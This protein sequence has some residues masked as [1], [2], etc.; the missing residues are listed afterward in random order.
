MENLIPC[1]ACGRLVSRTAENCP[2]C[3]KG[4]KKSQSAVGVVA[5]LVIGL[6][7]G[8]LLLHLLGFL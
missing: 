1:P 6:F 3:G 2:N 7:V 5:A 4:I 8:Y